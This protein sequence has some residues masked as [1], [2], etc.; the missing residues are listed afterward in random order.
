M[1]A[2]EK[3]VALYAEFIARKE[4][5]EEP[6]FEELV[7]GNPEVEMELRLLLVN[8]ARGARRSR[9]PCC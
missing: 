2:H 6:D 9:T 3:A 7:R 1:S 5:G 8:D 4:A